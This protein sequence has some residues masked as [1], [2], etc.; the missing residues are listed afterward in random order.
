[1]ELLYFYLGRTNVSNT[2]PSGQL[3]NVPWRRSSV[4]Y[5]NNEAYFDV[6][7]E[8]DAIIDKNGLV[9]SAEIQGKIFLFCFVFFF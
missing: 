3:S 5:T 7:E 4:K 6:T 1:M 9:V 8:L 2:L